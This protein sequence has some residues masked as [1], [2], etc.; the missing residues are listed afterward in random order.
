LRPSN[1]V[2]LIQ[3]LDCFASL[4]MTGLFQE[5]QARKKVNKEILFTY[6]KLSEDFVEDVLDIHPPQ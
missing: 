1:P 5:K 4:A 3:E 2:W 6:T